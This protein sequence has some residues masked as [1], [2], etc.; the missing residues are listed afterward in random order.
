[1]DV[2]TERTKVL[3]LQD[4]EPIQNKICIDYRILERV[5]KL[6][7]IAHTKRSRHIKQNCKIPKDSGNNK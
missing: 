1:M 7:H 5:N 6:S 2:L 4:K 3:A